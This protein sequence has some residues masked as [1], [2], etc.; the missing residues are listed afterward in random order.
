MSA[1]DLYFTA[2]LSILRSGTSPLDVLNRCLSCGIVNAGLGY[3]KTHGEDAFQQKLAEAIASAEAQGEEDPL[4]LDPWNESPL[5]LEEAL[6]GATIVGVQGGD[7]EQDTLNYKQHCEPDA[8]FFRIRSDWMWNAIHTT[9][10]SGEEEEK[11][12]KRKPLNWREFRI[13]AAI[14][15]AKVNS[16]GFTFLGWESIQARA[17]GFHSKALFEAGKATLPEHCQP[18]SRDVIRAEL[19]KLE[20]LGFFARCRYSKGER[21]GLMAYSLR[22]PK[23]EGLVQAI[24]K[25]VAD[26]QSFKAKVTALRAADMAAF[27]KRT[28]TPMPQVTPQARVLSPPLHHR[29]VNASFRPQEPLPSP[30]RYP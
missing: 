7:R 26:N 25:W 23:R 18:L 30:C 2:P 4:P 29:S 3:R 14:L 21:G 17:C 22:H 1:S 24:Q 9:D 19:E 15:S 5:Y 13:L 11:A 20:A 28:A 16:Y 8:V 27:T 10:E 6:V 12:E